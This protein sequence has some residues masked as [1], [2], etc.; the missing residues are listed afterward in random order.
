MALQSSEFDS[1]SFLRTFFVADS[2]KI[3]EHGPSW[4]RKKLPFLG[5]TFEGHDGCMKYFESL[6]QTLRMDLPEDAFQPDAELCV[7]A[8]AR[9]EG[10]AATGVVCV[11]G[12]GSFEFRATGWRW[13][14]KFIYRLS[15][16]DED[17]RVTHW[18]SVET[19]L[20]P[21]TEEIYLLS[22][23]RKF[24]LIL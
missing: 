6:D 12:K 14:E 15:G 8:D 13:D 17:G 2:P 19:F 11:T 1:H 24:G 5:Q 21:D 3:T 9:V 20:L 22:N 16:F 7:D 18:V 10:E 23:N 4:A